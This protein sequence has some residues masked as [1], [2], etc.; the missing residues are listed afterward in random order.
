MLAV[1]A[2]LFAGEEERIVFHDFPWGTSME[3]FISRTGRPVHSEEAN[4]ITTLIYDGVIISGYT[5]YM[6]A[7]F[8]RN[9]L[10]GGTYYFLTYSLDELM[11]CYLDVQK[12]LLDTYGPT[13]LCDGIIKELRPYETSW[14]LEKG[15]V[16]LKVNT[17]Q[18]EPVMLWFSSPR[19][20]REL[21]GS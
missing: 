8:S 7:Y 2:V 3:T 4:G 15:Y 13:R 5:T 21:R 16:Y 6:L 18:H 1:S 19:F 20:T 12:L 9:G 17:R 11:R 14:E 10:E